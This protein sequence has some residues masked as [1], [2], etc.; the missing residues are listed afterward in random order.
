[1]VTSNRLAFGNA[2]SAAR[3]ALGHNVQAPSASRVAIHRIS[4]N[5]ST[6]A[7]GIHPPRV[8]RLACWLSGLHRACSAGI[9]MVAAPFRSGQQTGLERDRE[10]SGGIEEHQVELDG[11]K[12]LLDLRE[13]QLLERRELDAGD[14]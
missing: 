4:E 13:G 12:L 6:A 9:S 2:V 3:V 7:P 14:T 11:R 1:M 8:R 5:T 10:A